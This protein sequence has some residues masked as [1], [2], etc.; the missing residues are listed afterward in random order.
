MLKLQRILIAVLIVSGTN[1]KSIFYFIMLVDSVIILLIM[2]QACM[3]A[4]S[5]RICMSRNSDGD[6]MF[7]R[8]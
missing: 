1:L 3:Y 8:N 2:M 7:Q 6:A 4:S 5:V